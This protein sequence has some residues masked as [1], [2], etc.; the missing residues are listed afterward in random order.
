MK[1]FLLLLFLAFLTSINSANLKGFFGNIKKANK[2]IVNAIQTCIKKEGSQ[3]L[4]EYFNNL[5]NMKKLRL[6]KLSAEDRKLYEKCQKS[7]TASSTQKI[8]DDMKTRLNKIKNEL[9][10]MLKK[11]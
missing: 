2:E 11:N 8:K 5:K 3:A 6:I 10:N 9:K 7:V 1:Q 4:K